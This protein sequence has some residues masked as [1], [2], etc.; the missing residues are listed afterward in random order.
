MGDIMRDVFSAISWALRL[1]LC[2]TLLTVWCV[3][4]FLFTG[5]LPWMVRRFF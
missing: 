5:R 1:V 2:C 3:I 4:V